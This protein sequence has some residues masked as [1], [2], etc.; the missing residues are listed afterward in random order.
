MLYQSFVKDSL[1]IIEDFQVDI[2]KDVILYARY[3]GQV[4]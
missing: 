3:V 2:P 1:K 4:V